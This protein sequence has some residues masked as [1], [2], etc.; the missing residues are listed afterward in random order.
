MLE[1]LHYAMVGSEAVNEFQN[2]RKVFYIQAR[3]E[4]QGKGKKKKE[5]L[6]SHI[7][8]LTFLFCEYDKYEFYTNQN[9]QA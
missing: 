9:R 6:K 1:S 4:W 5:D 8:Y 3:I 2:L 7:L